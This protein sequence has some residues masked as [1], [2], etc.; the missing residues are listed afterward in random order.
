MKPVHMVAVALMLGSLATG[1]ALAQEADSSD[2]FCKKPS[3]N[4]R[5]GETHEG[6]LYIVAPQNLN[7]YGTHRGDLIGYAGMT[8]IKGVVEGD[9]ILAGSNLDVDG[10]VMDS[11][12]YVGSMASANGTIHGD[13]IVMGAHLTLGP[14][15]RV[16]GDVIV[17]AGGI[18]MLGT[19]EGELRFTG[20]KVEIG[21]TV[22][23][24]TIL[25]ADEIRF[26][27]G[28]QLLGNLTY[29]ARKELDPELTGSVTAG[30]V[31]FEE[32]RDDDEEDEPWL[33]TS[34]I[35]WHLWANVAAL[36]VGIVVVA[37]FRGE[38][39]RL[40]ERVGRESVMATL[41]GFGTFLMVPTASALAIVL[42]VSLPL[43]V[44]ALGAF[45]IALYLAKIPVALWLGDRI[46]RLAG[47]ASPSPF[48]AVVVGVVLLYLLFALPFHIGFILWL[49]TTWLGLGATLLAVRDHR[50]PAAP[51]V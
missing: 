38:A 36:L 31:V 45:L 10:E 2:R 18:E 21:G 25:E 19:I 51:T 41:I 27:D 35:M 26:G 47:A 49:V 48:A 29:H 16:T 3:F 37:L 12:R 6:D 40:T 33:T 14:T 30:E 8:K 44:I 39:P 1:E 34:S 22:H 4:V 43:G 28:A 23:Q 50:Q 13:L 24:D 9:V 5:E 15:A 7:I 46:L 17:W 11:V 20:G 32:K 42:L